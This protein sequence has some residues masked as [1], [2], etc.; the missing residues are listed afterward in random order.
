[1]Y[2]CPIGGFCYPSFFHS[3]EH[4]CPLQIK[5][6]KRIGQRKNNIKKAAGAF[7]CT[8]Q[9]VKSQMATVRFRC[10]TK[11]FK[12]HTRYMNTHTQKYEEKRAR[13]KRI[14]HS[15]W[16][17][18]LYF[19]SLLQRQAPSGKKKKKSDSEKV[20]WCNHA[21][22][23]ALSHFPSP[24]LPSKAHALCQIGNTTKQKKNPVNLSVSIT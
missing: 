23:G 24:F 12:E 22:Q 21:L 11:C 17:E 8:D 2:P 5:K 1:M 3:G 19:L 13:G 14:V 4:M 18:L 6:E 20:L 7:M 15:P 10:W 9:V 16:G